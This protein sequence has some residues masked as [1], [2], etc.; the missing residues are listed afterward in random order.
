VPQVHPDARPEEKHQE[1][2][3]LDEDPEINP[4]ACLLLLAC[5][6]ALMVV[7]AEWLVDSIE[8]IQEEDDIQTSWFGIVLLPLASF[9]ADG[10]VTIGY[11]I[12]ASYRALRGEESPPA[13]LAKARAID[14]SIQ[15]MLFWLPLLVLIA[16]W[17]ERP[18]TLLFDFFHVALL[19]S[20]SFLVNYVTADAKTNW[21]EGVTM[22]AFYI[23]IVSVPV[24]PIPV[25]LVLKTLSTGALYLVLP[26]ST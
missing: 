11:F 9:S 22:V 24:F 2:R 18:L 12:H 4:W 8:G 17:T 26:R 25:F 14:L 1:K 3:L 5:T 13:V 6:V 23:I 20:A 7:T 21:A 16:W 19:L 10:A 15:F